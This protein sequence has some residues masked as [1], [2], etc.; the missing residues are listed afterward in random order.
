MKT[1]TSTEIIHQNEQVAELLK[2][3]RLNKKIP[4][5]IISEKLKI[6]LKYLKHIEEGSFEKLPSGVYG[7]NFLKE[8]SAFLGFDPDEILQLFNEELEKKSQ[9]NRKNIFS[10][11]IPNAHY[12]I[13]IPKIIKN[14][15]IA[16]IVLII[17]SYLALSIN[18]LISPPSLIIINPPTDTTIN[19]HSFIITG[20][21][22]I[23]ANVSINNE[24]VL[25]NQN[26]FFEKET[27]LKEGINN[28]QIIAQKK[29]SKKNIITRKIL[30]E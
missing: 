19:T 6:N 5:E 21:T 15:L 18:N 3:T 27:Y 1:F 7:K 22:D 16:L 14:S 9:K 13:T 10:R 17:I 30:V 29:Y 11:K 24:N 2:S 23:E 26:G 20:Q 4:L 12:F 25:I 28:I 8:Y